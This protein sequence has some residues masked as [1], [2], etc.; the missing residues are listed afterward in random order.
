MSTTV[1]QITPAQKSSFLFMLRLYM[2][3]C[4]VYYNSMYACIF[5]AICM[6]LPKKDI[7]I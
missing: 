7:F 1:K 2:S 5:G 4:S 3:T 6:I